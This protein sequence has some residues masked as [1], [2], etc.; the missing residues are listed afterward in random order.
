MQ[1]DGSAIDGDVEV[2][3]VHDGGA[4]PALYAG[5]AFTSI[6]GVPAARL[7]RYDGVGWSPVGTGAD[8]A[9][10]A[11]TTMN[12]ALLVGGDFRVM[13]G[14]SSARVAR[15]SDPCTVGVASY[16]TAGTSASGC[17]AVLST[18]GTPSASAA[19][20]F[21]ATA[22]DVEGGKDGLF[23]YGTQGP[24]AN[25]WG[26]GTSYQCVVPP[27]VRAG[28]QPGTGAAGSCDGLANQDLNALWSSAP[29]KNPGEGAT[30]QLQYWYRDPFGT[31]NQTTSLSDA[32]EFA[33]HP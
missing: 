31:S 28:L 19:S 10:Q 26:N 8:G 9:V 2:L 11:M 29:Q 7:A 3:F 18:S 21:V 22:Q 17:Q 23:F 12:G 27:V 30:V 4:G 1:F 25:P 5:G 14:L 32:L 13:G 16:C 24:Q 15:W 6:A 20:G 33:V